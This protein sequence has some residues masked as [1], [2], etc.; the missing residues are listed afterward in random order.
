MPLERGRR[1][2]RADGG[3][4]AGTA[5]GGEAE[6]GGKATGGVAVAGGGCAAGV[7]VGGGGE[8]H[9]GSTYSPTL[10]AP[11]VSVGAST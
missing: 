11:P 2:L 10:S 1:G 4:E 3:G 8:L 5:G 6:R 9:A 7:G